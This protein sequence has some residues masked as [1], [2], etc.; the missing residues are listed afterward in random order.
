MNEQ[1]KKRVEKKD[2]VEVGDQPEESLEGQVLAQT[3]ADLAKAINDAEYR[4][5]L[6]AEAEVDNS[7]SEIASQGARNDDEQKETPAPKERG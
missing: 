1:K 3:M 4:K 6:L 7:A 2:G 5:K